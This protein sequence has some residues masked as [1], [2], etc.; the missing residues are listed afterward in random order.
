[1]V[2][3]LKGDN[4]TAAS[5]RE[6]RKRVR[7]DLGISV[8]EVVFI[9]RNSMPK[10]SSGKVRRRETKARLEDRSLQFYSPPPRRKPVRV[11]AARASSPA[12]L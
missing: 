10:T 4:D 5:T 6:I 1:M 8:A 7:A 2:E 12:A 11:P 3:A 9:E